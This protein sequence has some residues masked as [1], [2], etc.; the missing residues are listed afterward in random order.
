MVNV[1][2]TKNSL[3][4]AWKALG[5]YVGLATGAPGSTATPSNEASGGSYA[6]VA[7]TWGSASGG[8]VTGSAVIINANAAT[9]SHGLIA[10]GSSGNN[11]IDNAALSPSIVLNAAGQ[12]VVTPSLTIS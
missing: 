12:V 7:T 3:A 11:M 1:T 4:D 2:A 6:R 10:S 5:A 8:V 9:Y